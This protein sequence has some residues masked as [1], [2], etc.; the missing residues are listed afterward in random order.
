MN[1][2]G[3]I[4]YRNYNNNLLK[5]YG[6]VLKEKPSKLKEKGYIIPKNLVMYI[7]KI[8]NISL[9]INLILYFPF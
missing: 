8:I 9:V 7:L 2:Y 3:I 5:S 6:I 1:N 4:F